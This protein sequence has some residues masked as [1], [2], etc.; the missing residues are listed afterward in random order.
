MLLGQ[1]GSIL[2]KQDFNV[3]EALPTVQLQYRGAHGAVKSRIKSLSLKEHYLL[4]KFKS[5]L[6]VFF[7]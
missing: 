1:T 5:R 2:W 6:R 4:N 7:H 3:A